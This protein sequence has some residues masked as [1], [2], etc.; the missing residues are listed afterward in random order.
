M[1]IIVVT[2]R[3]DG[4]KFDV[5]LG[6][7]LTKLSTKCI[8]VSETKDS[9]EASKTISNKYNVGILT[10]LQNNLISDNTIVMQI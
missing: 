6:P 2:P 9:D 4:D 7:S 10:A 1:E 5:M 3:F 8:N